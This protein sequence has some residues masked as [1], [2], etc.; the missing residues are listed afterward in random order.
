[1][2]GFEFLR[3]HLM[4]L[5]IWAVLVVLLGFY[6][7]RRRQASLMQ[8]VDRSQLQR[9]VPGFSRTR[10][11]MRVLFAALG[12]LFLAFAALGPVRGHT[13]REVRS[14]GLDIVCCIDTSRSMLTQDLRPS[15]LERAKREVRGLLDRLR[16]DRVALIAF[17]GDARE[18]APLTHD[19][20][21]LTGLLGYVS[22]RDNQMGGTNLAA[23]ITQ[24]L[25]LFDERN[26]AHEAICLLTDGEDLE[27]RGLELAREAADRGIRIYVVGIGT[28]GGGK[29]PVVR[30]GAA[31]FVRD[32][33]GNEVVSRLDGSSLKA[34]AE[35][36][37][38]AYLSAEASP[39]PL[40]DLYRARISKLEGRDLE[41]GKRQIPHDRFQWALVLG[42]TC[43]LI[44]S[45]LRE[46]RFSDQ[47]LAQKG[48]AA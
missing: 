5:P 2:I 8:L 21:T 1:M 31:Q 12:I 38:G 26:G 40:E 4:W 41:G 32:P 6:G 15:R 34:L 33:D 29:I 43:M 35:S 47:R 48:I 25:S 11:A 7:L 10:S 36:T 14:R 9:F 46:R 27:G 18:I 16:G 45:G 17:S 20:V 42:I 44:E 39:T 37:G 13:W 3:P 19:R 28:E 23:A 30:D 22:P 24:A